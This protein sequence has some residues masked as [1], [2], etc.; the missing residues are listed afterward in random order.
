MGMGPHA[1]VQ[2]ALSGARLG[3]Q[4]EQYTFWHV[5]AFVNSVSHRGFIRNYETNDGSRN[6]LLLDTCAHGEGWQQQS[7]RRSLSA[8]MHAIVYGSWIRCS[9][10]FV[11]WRD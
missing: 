11:S 6:N 3:S 5:S 10:S 4:P 2:L 7:S 1:A 9:G 8:A